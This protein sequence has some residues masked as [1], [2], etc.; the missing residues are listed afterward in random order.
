MRLIAH[1]GNTDGKNPDKENH[2]DYIEAAIKAG[3]D[4][5]IDIRLIDGE[6][7][8]GHDEPRY[9]IGEPQSDMWF[10]FLFKYNRHLWIHC[11][12]LEAFGKLFNYED[13]NVFWHDTDAVVLTSQ[14]FLWTFPNK[15]L[16]SS[17]IC[18]L[19]ELGINGDLNRCYGLC[20]DFP[21]EYKNGIY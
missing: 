13:L 7:W 2:P 21:V 12:N 15:P 6:L 16:L 17:S 20:S 11:K 19:P 9:N 3:F 4:A 10:N 5:E 8:L 14:R 18:V 1:R